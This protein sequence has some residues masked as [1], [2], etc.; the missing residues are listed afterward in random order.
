MY[1]FKPTLMLTEKFGGKENEKETDA[2][3]G[4]DQAKLAERSDDERLNINEVK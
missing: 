1:G 2:R 4:G 3:R